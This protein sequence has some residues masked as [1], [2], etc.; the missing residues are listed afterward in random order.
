MFLKVGSL[1]AQQ[2]KKGGG[3][4]GGEDCLEIVFPIQSSWCAFM[5]VSA[6]YNLLCHLASDK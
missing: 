5:H 6:Y 2:K 4:G 3:G 1:V